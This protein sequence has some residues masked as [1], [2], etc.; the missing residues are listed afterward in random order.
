[1]ASLTLLRGDVNLA[2]LNGLKNDLGGLAIDLA[3]N[4]VGGTEDLP[5]G[6]LELLGERLVTH[7]AGNVDDLIEGDGLVVLDVLLLLAIARGLLEGANDEGGSGR[8]N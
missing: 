5:D 7:S 3:A 1:M 6:A 8:H 4:R 2:V